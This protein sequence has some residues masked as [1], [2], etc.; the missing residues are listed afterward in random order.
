MKSVDKSAPGMETSGSKGLLGPN[1]ALVERRA[2]WQR[3]QVS[4]SAVTLSHMPRGVNLARTRWKVAPVPGCPEV[5]ISWHT[6]IA[7]VMVLAFSL[8]AGRAKRSPWVK[9]SDSSK[10][11]SKILPSLS[12]R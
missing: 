12:L 3:W 5:V 7:A 4:T 9:G 1:G 8:T 11:R 10:E 2:Y 6:R